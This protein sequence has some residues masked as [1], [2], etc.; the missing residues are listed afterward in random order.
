MAALWAWPIGGS[1]LT[2]WLPSGGLQL[3]PTWFALPCR[4]DPVTS[5]VTTAPGN[6]SRRQTSSDGPITSISTNPTRYDLARRSHYPLPGYCLRSARARCG[7]ASGP[8]P[9]ATRVGHGSKH[10]SPG[11]FAG[12]QVTLDCHF[13]LEREYEK[14]EPRYGIEP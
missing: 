10:L 1:A 5:Q 3:D 14:C 9:R 11:V 8:S 2:D 4:Q 7:W 6:G 12:F 13:F